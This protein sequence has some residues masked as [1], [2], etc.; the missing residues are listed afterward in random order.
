MFISIFISF[1]NIFF[2]LRVCRKFFIFI[3]PSPLCFSHFFPNH[4]NINCQF[5]IKIKI[6]NIF[7]IFYNLSTSTFPPYLSTIPIASFFLTFSKIF[8][9]YMSLGSHDPKQVVAAA[10]CGDYLLSGTIPIH[11]PFYLSIQLL[12]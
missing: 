12:L 7:T 6:I 5:L 2:P 3:Y 9:F 1:S 8:T 11:N 10:F 4:V